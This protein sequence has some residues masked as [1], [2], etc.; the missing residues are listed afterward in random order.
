MAVQPAFIVQRSER[1]AAP[2]DVLL[3]RTFRWLARLPRDIRPMELS[4]WSPRIA[5]LLAAN[6]DEPEAMRAYL[7]DLLLDR[8]GG[9]QGFPPNVNS[10]LLA[11]RSFYQVLFPPAAREAVGEPQ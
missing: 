6:W 2:F 11:F 3:P 8:R 10:E 1:K 9:R 5:N 7:E 4:R